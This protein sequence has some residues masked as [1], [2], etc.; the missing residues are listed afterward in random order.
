[1]IIETWGGKK[2]YLQLMIKLEDN[3]HKTMDIAFDL[4]FS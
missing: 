1:M 4:K 3:K 2:N